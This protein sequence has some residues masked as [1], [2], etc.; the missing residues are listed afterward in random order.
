M[1]LTATQDTGSML[2]RSSYDG[3]GLAGMDGGKVW[4][5]AENGP[6]YRAG[7]REGDILRGLDVLY[8]G[9]FPVGTMVQ[10]EKLYGNKWVRLTMRIEMICRD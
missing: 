7:I 3:I 1:I 10:V 9:K 4:M 2:C 5:V 8:P 6:A